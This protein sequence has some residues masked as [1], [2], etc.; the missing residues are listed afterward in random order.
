VWERIAPIEHLVGHT[1]H[2]LPSD[3]L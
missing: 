3:S 1:C 2:G